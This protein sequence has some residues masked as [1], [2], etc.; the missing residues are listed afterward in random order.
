MTIETAPNSHRLEPLKPIP[1]VAAL[2][3]ASAELYAAHRLLNEFFTESDP[4]G[5]VM[6]RRIVRANELIE[7]VVKAQAA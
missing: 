4:D 3:L 7:T 5:Q 2:Q 1:A 6:M